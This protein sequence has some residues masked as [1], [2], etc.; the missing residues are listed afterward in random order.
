[1]TMLTAIIVDECD[2]IA[3]ILNCGVESYSGIPALSADVPAIFSGK[4]I[5]STSD[6]FTVR[7]LSNQAGRTLYVGLWFKTTLFTSAQSLIL[8]TGA[9]IASTQCGIGINTSGNLIIYRNTTATVLATGTTVLSLDTWHQLRASIFVNNTTGAVSVYLNGNP[10]AEVS[11]TGAD[12]QQQTTD[13]VYLVQYSG[14]ATHLYQPVIFNDQ[15]TKNNA[16]VPWT[17]M[18]EILHPTSDGATVWTQNTGANAYGA[19]DEVQGSED[20][21]TTYLYETSTVKNVMG[22]EDP[23]GSVGGVVG[24]I[25]NSRMRRGAAGTVGVKVGVKVST[26]EAQTS[27]IYLPGSY[28]SRLDVFEYKTGTTV[29]ASADLDSLELTTEHL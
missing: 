5:Y 19:I 1:M 22:M 12:T 29:F 15:G 21:D 9:A 14:I 6:P 28:S 16:A 17:L 18:H 25:V 27:T 26:D 10:S 2:S 4:S 24:V 13:E 8:I 3:D 23:A 11:V 7:L 20:D